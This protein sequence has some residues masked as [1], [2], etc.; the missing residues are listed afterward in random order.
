MDKELEQKLVD[1]YP[2]LYRE[3][4]GDVRETCMGWGFSCNDGWYNILEELSFKIKQLDKKERVVADQVKEKFGGLRFYY[5]IE[6]YKEPRLIPWSLWIKI[7]YKVRT[8]LTEFRKLFFKTFLEKVNDLI[9]DAERQSY[10]TC[11]RCGEPG[12]RIA[13]GWVRTLC[14]DCEAIYQDPDADF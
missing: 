3:Y 11:E 2:H 4:G 6:N 7:P 9:E 8:T 14:D 13:G 5:H 12:R 10:K 1:A